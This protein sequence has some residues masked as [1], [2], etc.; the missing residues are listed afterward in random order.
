MSLYD[1]LS[2]MAC[3]RKYLIKM[4]AVKARQTK[5]SKRD[6][7]TKKKR[8]GV[9]YIISASAVEGGLLVHACRTR[10]RDGNHSM[11]GIGMQPPCLE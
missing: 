1:S 10:N 5:A 2:R 4:M 9:L 3:K 6:C 8:R 11:G 7:G